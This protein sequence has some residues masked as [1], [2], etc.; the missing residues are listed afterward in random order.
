MMMSQDCGRITN[1]LTAGMMQSQHLKITA[2]IVR[3]LSEATAA[4]TTASESASANAT[5][6]I[7]LLDACW[8][9][10]TCFVALI[11]HASE[12]E[13]VQNEQTATNRNRNTQCCTV[14]SEA[15]T[16]RWFIGVQLFVCATGSDATNDCSAPTRI[17]N[18]LAASVLFACILC[19][20]RHIE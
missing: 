3:H 4:D 18:R 8:F 9:M 17:A 12:D 10:L 13:N 6:F 16:N 2:Y 7:S 11:V 1:A 14:G 15:I 19:S 20:R 5:I